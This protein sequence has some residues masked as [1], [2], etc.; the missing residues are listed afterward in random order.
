M[1]RDGEIVCQML[2]DNHC[3]VV[4]LHNLF[5]TPSAWCVTPHLCGVGSIH[6]SR[7]LRQ[8]CTTG[9]PSGSTTGLQDWAS[10]LPV[11]QLGIQFINRRPVN[12]PHLGGTYNI[13]CRHT[14]KEPQAIYMYIHV[15]ACKPTYI[16]KL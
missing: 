16:T 4:Q 12:Q 1:A 10:G 8:G 5:V 11:N 7:A 2:L 9:C 15:H 14:E 6:F 3:L 13:I